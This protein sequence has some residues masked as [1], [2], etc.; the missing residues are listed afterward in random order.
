[1]KKSIAL[2]AFCLAGISQTA[3]AYE[4]P[5][6]FTPNAGYRG[7]IVAGY[8]FVNGNVVG[9]CSYFTVSGASGSK[10]GGGRAPAKT[11]AQTCTWDLH[12][13]LLSV[14]PGAPKI[15]VPVA[16]KGSQIIFAI[17][18]NGNYT[19]T[20]VKLP[21][22]G[23]VNSPGSHYTW[24]TPSN[25]AVLQQ[26]A[27]TLTATLKSDGDMPV[28]ISD[29]QVSAL[30]GVVT[31]KQTNCKGEINVGDKCSITVSY[32]PTKV[33]GANGLASDTL[34]ID[35]TSD[36]GG[37]HDFIQNFTVILPQN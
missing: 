26:I 31:L 4:Y 1:M 7:L 32:D 23:F 22:L 35:L 36:A 11:Y 25:A 3:F 16:S 6:Q 13:N 21:H 27:Y 33:T 19:G 34:R 28:N 15:P 9:N 2:A 29:V 12:G 24:L 30:N 5:L 10:G 17:D 18:A 8:K 14:A 37:A 20:D